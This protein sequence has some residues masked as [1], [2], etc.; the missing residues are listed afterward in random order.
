MRIRN[1]ILI[2]LNYLYVLNP[3]DRCLN[4]AEQAPIDY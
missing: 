3:N 2:V 4:S 1:L